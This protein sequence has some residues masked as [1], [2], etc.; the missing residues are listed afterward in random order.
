MATTTEAAGAGL[1]KVAEEL[2]RPYVAVFAFLG[3]VTLVEVQIPTLGQML[4]ISQVLQIVFLL[5][6]A[7]LV[8]LYYM[9]LR[10]EP[11]ILKILPAFP[12]IFVALLIAVVVVH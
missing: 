12:L 3:L 4:G 5:G 11:R 9:H 2:K 6:T 7:I 1:G 10:Y 8:A